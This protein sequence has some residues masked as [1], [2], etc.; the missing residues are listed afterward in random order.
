MRTKRFAA[1]IFAVGILGLACEAAKIV[2]YDSHISMEWCYS[3]SRWNYLAYFTVITNFAVDLWM[4]VLAITIFAKKERL[5]VFLTLPQIQGAL[6][7]YIGTV[8]IV[9]CVFLFWFIGPFSSNLWWANVIDMWSHLILPA[10]MF[11]IWVLTPAP[12][13]KIKYHTLLFWLIPPLVYFILSEIRG[14][15]SDWYPYPF[16]RPSLIMFP[17][18]IL[19]SITCFV[20]VGFLIILLQ[21]RK[22]KTNLQKKKK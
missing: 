14:L 18:G 1:G 6:V 16:F 10:F 5:H 13:T 22:Y 12:K 21:N 2:F 11:G 4:I 20:V 15:V 9:Y 7:L 8:S 19:I 3:V 17:V